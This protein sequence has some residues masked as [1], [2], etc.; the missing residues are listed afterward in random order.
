L[1]PASKECDFDL[2]DHE[3]WVARAGRVPVLRHG[4]ALGRPAAVQD[5]GLALV[6]VAT[7]PISL[8]EVCR[9]AFGFEFDNDLGT[10]RALRRAP[11]GT[12][13]CSAAP[14]GYLYD[15]ATVIADLAAFVA[16]C[17]RNA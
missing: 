8:A 4:T 5:H 12:I 6:N 17:R 10:G 7:E 9:D 1:A 13:P 3:T 15:R 11:A 16:S 14:A 2:H